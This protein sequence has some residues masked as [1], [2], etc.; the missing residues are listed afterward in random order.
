MNIGLVSYHREPNYGTMLQA[1]ALANA[2]QRE[3]VSCAYLD[4]WFA[5]KP[6]WRR[7]A[8]KLA[9]ALGLTNKG[10][11]AFFGTKEFRCIRD[12][13][14]AFHKD[15]IPVS[16]RRYYADNIECA[17]NDYDKFIVGSDQTWSPYM[18]RNPHSINFL[19]FVE[20]GARKSAYAPSF[21][22]LRITKDF[23]ERLSA[24]LESFKY[25]SCRERQNC[26]Y[27]SSLLDREIT[28][29][30]DPTLLLDSKEWDKIAIQP[31]MRN[32][33]YILA[34]ILG[35]KDCITQYA[36]MLGEKYHLP[37]YYIA[38]RPCYLHRPHVLDKVGPQEFIGL[39]RNAAYIVTDSFHGT[40]FSIN[41]QK[42]FYS[43]AK[44][45]VKMGE[46]MNDNDRIL[47]FLQELGLENRFKEDDDI[48]LELPIDYKNIHEHLGTMRTFSR[49]YLQKIIK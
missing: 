29:V 24:L 38:T 49:L 11:F 22:T 3:G 28:Y 12:K 25:I 9:C 1:Y 2:V 23:G 46:V 4:Y 37:V 8:L 31:S 45:E 34:Y 6:I 20:D 43:F 39:I 21:G 16:R 33:E 14:A 27:L 44:R 17:L 40:L 7:L 19:Q 48:S 18:N 10:E 5:R 47:A 35:E 36:E 30:V 15:F 42:E 26:A 41:Y 13:F 32:G